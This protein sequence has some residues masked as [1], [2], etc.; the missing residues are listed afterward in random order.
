MSEEILE[1][2]EE[3]VAPAS[4]EAVVEPIAESVIEEQPAQ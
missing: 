4:V 3:V 2:V 1:P